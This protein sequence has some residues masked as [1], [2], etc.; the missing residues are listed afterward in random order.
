[1]EDEKAKF[2]CSLFPFSTVL[3]QPWEKLRSFLSLS[4]SGRI[5]IDFPATTILSLTQQCTLLSL[6]AL[7]AYVQVLGGYLSGARSCSLDYLLRWMD[8]LKEARQG[9]RCGF[10]GLFFFLLLLL[11]LLILL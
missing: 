4:L 5:Q 10:L 9:E 2:L 1:M 11:I 7:Y 3:C 6:P 8:R